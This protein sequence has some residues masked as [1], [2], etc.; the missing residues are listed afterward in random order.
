M[1]IIL[2]KIGFSFKCSFFKKKIQQK[3]KRRPFLQSVCRYISLHRLG[4]VVFDCSTTPRELLLD[5]L[6]GFLGPLDHGRTVFGAIACHSSDQRQT[7]EYTAEE[8]IDAGDIHSQISG[9]L[10]ESF[11]SKLGGKSRVQQIRSLGSRGCFD[12]AELKQLET[13]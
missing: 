2:S 1:Y 6:V 5:Q 7:D 8:G 11:S 12:Q 4:D 10:L 13:P 9:S 3:Q